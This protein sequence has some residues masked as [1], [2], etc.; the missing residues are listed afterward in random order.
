MKK[1]FTSSVMALAV[2]GWPAVIIRPV[3]PVVL[4]PDICMERFLEC[5]AEIWEDY[6]T[7]MKAKNNPV[8]CDQALKYRGNNCKISYDL[9]METVSLQQHDE[10]LI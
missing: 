1:Y 7:C 8:L 3:A 2:M 6:K 10:P 5:H 4:T 9:C